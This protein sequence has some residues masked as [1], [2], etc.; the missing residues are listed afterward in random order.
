[1]DSFVFDHL[2]QIHSEP[3]GLVV[4]RVE[5]L[6][7]RSSP[8]EFA[9]VIDHAEHHDNDKRDLRFCVDDL[10][11]GPTLEARGFASIIMNLLD[12]ILPTWHLS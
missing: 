7:S 6:K 5:V 3:L 4:R 10:S 9:Q 8:G 2:L 11:L 1:M 12:M